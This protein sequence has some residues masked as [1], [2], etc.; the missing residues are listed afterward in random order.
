MDKKLT[1]TI[2]KA[3]YALSL[4]CFSIIFY[5]QMNIKIIT[6]FIIIISA[7]LIILEIKDWYLGSRIMSNKEENHS[8][9]ERFLLSKLFSCILIYITPVYCII[10]GPNLVI[11]HFVSS[12]TITIISVL[13]ILAILL[14][15]K[16]LSDLG[17]INFVKLSS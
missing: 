1:L 7:I 9:K 10:Q 6:N 11:S 16:F 13:A 2:L 12:I 3:V 14:E 8:S 5:I 15:K 17:L 4:I